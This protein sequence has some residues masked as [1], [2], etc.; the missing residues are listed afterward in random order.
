[1]TENGETFDVE[2]DDQ[3]E[4][5]HGQSSPPRSSRST[6]TRSC[7][8]TSSPASCRPRTAPAAA[9]GTSASSSSPKSGL[10]TG[11][12]IRNVAADHVRRQPIDR[13]RP[14]RRRGS[15]PGRRPDQAGP[16]HH[17]RR[18]ADQQRRRRCRPT[19]PRPASPSAGRARTTPAARASPSYNI[20]VSDDG[21]PFTLW[22]SDT[23]AT[24]AT[25]TG[26]AGH[27]YGFYSVAT[28]NVGLVQP[29]PTGAQA[30]TKIVVPPRGA[31]VRGRTVC[32][33]R[34]GRCGASRDQPRRQPECLADRD[35]VQPRRSRR[36][37]VHEDSD[38]RPERDQ[39][40]CHDPDQQRRPAGR[41]Q[42]DHPADAVVAGRR[43]NARR[44]HDR[45]PRHPRQQ[46][47]PG[48]L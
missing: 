42:H 43:S 2:I 3:P 32:R 9:W 20:Y 40:D 23:T 46:P 45:Q 41:E 28:D 12:Q 17:R 15:Q 27:T 18:P 22:Q 4:P 36:H 10:P 39:P 47:V 38:D 13:H 30:T 1:M 35:P 31:S 48:R 21:G 33:Q 19:R 16:H 29:T 34:H 25:F 5:G 24:S 14:G 26:A 7:R 6:R 11:T 37:G 8:P 44:G